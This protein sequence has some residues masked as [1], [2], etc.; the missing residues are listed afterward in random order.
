VLDAAFD[1]ASLN[2]SLLPVSI[3]EDGGSEGTWLRSSILAGRLTFSP[4]GTFAL[5][6]TSEHADRFGIAHIRSVRSVGSYRFI[7]SGLDPTSG[8]VTL[9]S[10]HGRTTHAAITPISLVHLTQVCSSLGARATC[11]W[12]YLR[13]AANHLDESLQL[14]G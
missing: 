5:V 4:E 6:I 11:T 13:S 12:V 9:I 8:E 1:L 3:E 14:A 7:P 10:S 2:G